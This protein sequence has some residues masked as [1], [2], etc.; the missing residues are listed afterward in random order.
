MERLIIQC[1][2]P[3]FISW[4]DIIHEYGWHYR[5]YLLIASFQPR[6]RGWGTSG[7]QIRNV[8]HQETN[9]T[10]SRERT[11]G[12]IFLQFNFAFTYFDSCKTTC[13]NH[14]HEGTQR[15]NPTLPNQRA[16]ITNT[17]NLMKRLLMRI[18]ALNQSAIRNW[19]YNSRQ[20]QKAFQLFHFK[21]H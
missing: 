12:K 21:F 17:F 6:A 18:G 10:Y 3:F 8:C 15:W 11:M 5:H 4:T 13:I 14:T 7:Q 2:N 9:V 16:Q 20:V 1:S 19:N